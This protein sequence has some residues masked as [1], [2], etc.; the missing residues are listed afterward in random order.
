M[1]AEVRS[2]EVIA[3][4]LDIILQK[5]EQDQYR[6][7]LFP[8]IDLSLTYGRSAFIRRNEIPSNYRAS[9]TLRWSI[10]RYFEVQ[11]ARETFLSAENARTLQLKFTK[12][13]N[14]IQVIDLYLDWLGTEILVEKLTTSKTSTGKKLERLELLKNGSTAPNSIQELQSQLNGINR[15][16]N[17]ANAQLFTTEG[18]L[19]KMCG[20]KN[21]KQVERPTFKD[22]NF[23][24]TPLKN[25]IAESLVKSEGIESSE[26][27]SFVAS[28]EED[29]ER[30]ARF[31]KIS[32][33]ASLTDILSNL[34]SNILTISWAYELIDQG[35]FN[36]KI[37]KARANILLADLE[38]AE[39]HKNIYQLA[40]NVWIS[41]LDAT[42]DFNEIKNTRQQ[43]QINFDVVSGQLSTGYIDPF[44]VWQTRSALK[45][46]K[47]EEKIAYLEMAR[48]IS[49]YET[50]TSGE[51]TRWNIR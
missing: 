10:F 22:F 27:L 39:Q 12:K 37:L 13:Q 14:H 40:G 21:L 51:I 20:L 44:H 26:L 30:I 5:A 23:S 8:Q 3:S 46:D 1:L 38:V 41:L 50:L 36:R 32:I 4:N 2:P 48:A 34:S 6:S 15:S 24:P 47:Y 45:I 35:N 49:H 11:K 7:I 29:K 16:L 25:Y 19:A 9:P 18:L 43:Q 31:S 33:Y 28:K 42:A 17:I